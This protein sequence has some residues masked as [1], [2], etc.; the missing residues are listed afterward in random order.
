VTLEN[1]HIQE[2]TVSG[3]FDFT[4]LQGDPSP[5][6]NA[7]NFQGVLMATTIT[8]QYTSTDDDSECGF[9]TGSIKTITGTIELPTNHFWGNYNLQNDNGSNIVE[10]PG[11]FELWSEENKPEKIV[12]EG[13][14]FNSQVNRGG[15]VIIEIMI[16]SN[17]DF[18]HFPK[19]RKGSKIR[20]VLFGFS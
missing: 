9:D 7:G 5:L 19:R 2:A 18:I 10:T 13:T 14:A 3:F 12:Y 1:F 6:C 15:S 11:V 4:Q 8:G 20:K 17:L 16:G